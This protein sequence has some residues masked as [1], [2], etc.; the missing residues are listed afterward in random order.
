MKLRPICYS[1]GKKKKKKEDHGGIYSFFSVAVTKY[2]KPSGSEQKLI[3]SQFHRPEAQDQSVNTATLSLKVQD[4]FQASF[5]A[6]GSLRC[7]LVCRSFTIILH[8]HMV[9]PLLISACVQILLSYKNTSHIV[10][11]SSQMISF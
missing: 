8:L 10:L 7:S 3:L 9:F 4:L 6:F 5:L 11:C 2:H 1:S